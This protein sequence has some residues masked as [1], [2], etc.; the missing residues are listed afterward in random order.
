MNFCNFA[1]IILARTTKDSNAIAW[2]EKKNKE[3]EN[4]SNE[5]NKIIS[6]YNC[7]LSSSFRHKIYNNIMFRYPKMQIAA[8]VFQKRI[9]NLQKY[10][11]ESK[12]YKGNNKNGEKTRFVNS[13]SLQNWE[14]LSHKTA[15]HA[16]MK[17]KHH[18]Y[19]TELRQLARYCSFTNTNDRIRSQLISH[20]QLSQLRKRVFREPDK[21]TSLDAVIELGRSMEAADKYSAQIE[22]DLGFAKAI[23]T[24][25][26]NYRKPTI[27]GYRGRSRNRKRDN[28]NL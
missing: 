12:Y 14:Q 3:N 8:S 5:N 26:T 15:S 16:I 24:K 9:K 25:H 27:K 2:W 4:N 20:C 19:I 10:V 23:T 18:Y 28:S 13:F 22:R 11:A 21:Y 7:C 1:K 6:N 17:M